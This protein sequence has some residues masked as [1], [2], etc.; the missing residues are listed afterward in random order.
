MAGG[1]KGYG[2]PFSIAINPFRKRARQVDLTRLSA[3]SRQETALEVVP[4][5]PGKSAPQHAVEA[6][7]F[8]CLGREEAAEEALPTGRRSRS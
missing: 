5:L 2:E 6:S 4:E 3:V 1:G 8:S 7:V